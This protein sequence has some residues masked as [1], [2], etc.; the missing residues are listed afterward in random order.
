MVVF[1]LLNTA[2][3][4]CRGSMCYNWTLMMLF[5]EAVEMLV[6]V[7]DKNDVGF[8]ELLLD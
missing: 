8:V 2:V 4:N 3:R 5:T 1:L 7:L 6:N